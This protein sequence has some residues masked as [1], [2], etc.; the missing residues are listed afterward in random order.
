MGIILYGKKPDGNEQCET[1][2]PNYFFSGINL[3]RST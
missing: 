2:K 1:S 3:M